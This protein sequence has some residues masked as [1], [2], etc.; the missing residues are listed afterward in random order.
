MMC[1]W[2][3]EGSSVID[4]P[5][6]RRLPAAGDWPKMRIERRPHQVSPVEGRGVASASGENGAARMA[7]HVR[8]QGRIF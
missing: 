6:P 7:T 8:S 3:I 4:R 5:N 2:L 1:Y